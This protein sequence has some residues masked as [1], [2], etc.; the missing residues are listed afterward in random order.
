MAAESV[1]ACKRWGSHASRFYG[2]GFYDCDED[3]LRHVRS[4]R[5]RVL[6]GMCLRVRC[7]H[8]F[9]RALL[10]TVAGKGCLKGT[11]K[12]KGKRSHAGGAGCAGRTGRAGD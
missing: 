6:A 4:A 3:A 7:F 2:V 10:E 8:I 12:F 5:E 9:M 1:A 11:I